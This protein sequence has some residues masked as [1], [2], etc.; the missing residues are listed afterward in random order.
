MSLLLWAGLFLLF[1]GAAPSIAIEVLVG[2]ILVG[3]VGPKQPLNFSHFFGPR[4][5]LARSTRTADARV[6]QQSQ[7]I[8][9]VLT[10]L[11]CV[12]DAIP[13]RRRRWRSQVIGRSVLA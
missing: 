10:A 6:S 1:L 13:G 4:F 11:A 5:V 9:Y 2:G 7:R 8:R 3:G 12:R